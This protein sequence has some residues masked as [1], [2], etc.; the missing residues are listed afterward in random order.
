MAS[1]YIKKSQVSTADA[2]KSVERGNIDSK[3][4][5]KDIAKAGKDQAK[6]GIKTFY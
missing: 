2:A 4:P 1:R 5:D 6:K 3:S